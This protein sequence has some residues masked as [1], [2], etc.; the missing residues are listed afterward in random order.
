MHVMDT[1]TLKVED[2]AGVRIYVRRLFR[3]TFEYLI[4]M[5]GQIFA[6][7]VEIRR[8]PGRRMTNY[9]PEDL[10]NAIVFMLHV[11]REFVDDRIADKKFH[12]SFGERWRRTREKV[13]D[14][15][16]HLLNKIDDIKYGIERKPKGG[17]G[18]GHGGDAEVPVEVVRTE[19]R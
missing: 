14:R 5:D 12:D 11:A 18:K 17:K 10:E 3:E 15:W 16:Y 2:Y 13:E 6:N 19:G 8:E 7:Q 4:L 1:P 9:S